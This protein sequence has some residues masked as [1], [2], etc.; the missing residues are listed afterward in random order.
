MLIVSRFK[1]Y[2]EGKLTSLSENHLESKSEEAFDSGSECDLRKSD[3]DEDA[4]SSGTGFQNAE[5]R[6]F[7]SE[8]QGML[9]IIPSYL[10]KTKIS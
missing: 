9:H 8:L 2:E 6:D 7:E 10:V 3:N 5:K 1:N 4:F